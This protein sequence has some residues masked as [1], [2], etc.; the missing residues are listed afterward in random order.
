MPLILYSLE[1]SR[2]SWISG[3][4]QRRRK[5]CEQDGGRMVKIQLSIFVT[6]TDGCQRK[7]L[8]VN[9]SMQGTGSH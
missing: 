9:A 6:H 7:Y 3:V 5:E 1:S 4:K 2:P 8:T